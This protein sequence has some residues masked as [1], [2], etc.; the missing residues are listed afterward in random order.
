[1]SHYCWFSIIVRNKANKDPLGSYFHR[2][3]PRDFTEKLNNDNNNSNDNN[4]YNNNSNNKLNPTFTVFSDYNW[5]VYIQPTPCS[6][7]L[8]CSSGGGS[9]M[10]H[11]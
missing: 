9:A 10:L 8:N 5:L 6:A 4:G 11:C 1:M 3:P 7:H 2:V